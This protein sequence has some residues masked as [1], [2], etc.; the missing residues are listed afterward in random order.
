M[1]F[2]CSP[3]VRATAMSRHLSAVLA[4]CLL[5]A[6]ALAADSSALDNWAG[7]W[8]TGVE[9]QITIS[10]DGDVLEIDGYASYGGNDPERVA[11][12]AVNVGS[13]SGVV[14]ASWIE[15]GN[16]LR[17]AVDGGT[18]VA[19]ETAVDGL[20][21]VELVLDGDTL[22]AEDNNACGGLNV[23]FSGQYSRVAED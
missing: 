11:S 10:V 15:A 19:L 1:I 17:F 5:A 4:G 16:R 23:S 22:T 18:P 9:E 7:E 2:K 21:T 12:G 14:P 6:P 3:R 20:C 13:F 8:S